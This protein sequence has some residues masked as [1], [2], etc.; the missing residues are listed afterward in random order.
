MRATPAPNVHQGSDAVPSDFIDEG[1]CV[2]QQFL[3]HA[4]RQGDGGFINAAHAQTCLGD[5][6]S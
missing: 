2:A 3:P 6:N 1:E 4:L 5:C